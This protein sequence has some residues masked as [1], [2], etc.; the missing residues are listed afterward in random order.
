M[1]RLELNIPQ[2]PDPDTP[3]NHIVLNNFRI[4][5]VVSVPQDSRKRS[6]SDQ[7]IPGSS[8]LSKRV[9]WPA[10][11][12]CTA[13]NGYVGLPLVFFTLIGN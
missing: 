11:F 4:G 2:L 7:F 6:S 13:K 3:D 1:N 10:G 12:S 5:P 9:A 8:S